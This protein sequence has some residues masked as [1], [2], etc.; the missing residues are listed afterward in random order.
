MKF[1]GFI[2]KNKS[3]ILVISAFLLV[4]IFFC[5][6]LLINKQ[7]NTISYNIYEPTVMPFDTTI[8]ERRA[9]TNRRSDPINDSPSDPTY[10]IKFSNNDMNIFQNKKD[11]SFNYDD[12]IKCQEKNYVNSISDCSENITLGGTKYKVEKDYLILDGTTSIANGGFN[13]EVN[14]LIDDTDVGMFINCNDDNC[15]YLNYDWGPFIDSFKQVEQP[16]DLKIEHN[17]LP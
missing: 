3:I 15:K 1:K 16:K 12:Y 9:Y 2:N 17:R 4:I 10:Q 14:F 6:G 13:Y 8:T 11:N 5:Y 7:N